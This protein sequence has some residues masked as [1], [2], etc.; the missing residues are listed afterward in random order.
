[1][2]KAGKGGGD[3]LQQKSPAEF[4]AENKNIAGFDN[5]GKCLYTTIRE[6]VENA[7]DSAESISTLPLV[8]ITIEEI[9]KAHLNQL[10]G[11]DNHE[12]VDEE[13]YNDFENEDAK[14]KRLA[15]EARD[16]E[17]LEKLAA[18][19]GEAVAAA[20]AAE[21]QRKAADGRRGAAAARGT[22]FY[23]VT[24][25]VGFEGPAVLAF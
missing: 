24:V 20:A 2:S 17:R 18:K 19:K 25:K 15:K 6:L 7:L 12:R 23:K 22:L 9:S 10:R 11:L 21:Q 3:K 14:K 1:M 5:P 16:K 4:F 8:E 13:L